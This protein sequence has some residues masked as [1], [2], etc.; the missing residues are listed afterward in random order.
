MPFNQDFG[1][2]NLA[3]VHRY[4]RE[5][6]RLLSVSEDFIITSMLIK[7]SGMHHCRKYF[8]SIGSFAASIALRG[9]G[10]ESKKLICPKYQNADAIN[11]TG[12][13]PQIYKLL[14]MLLKI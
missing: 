3:M 4:C 9:S 12:L 6:S 13:Y 2:L 11:T 8:S 14:N 7:S 10:S 1:P 5:L